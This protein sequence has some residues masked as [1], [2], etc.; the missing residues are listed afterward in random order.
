MLST[1]FT[2]LPDDP[3]Q[4][5]TTHIAAYRP[6]PPPEVADLCGT[7][8]LWTILDGADPLESESW[9]LRRCWLKQN[10]IFGV[11]N[12]S[13]QFR[14][15]AEGILITAS[16]LDNALEV[17]LRQGTKF[18]IL[19]EDMSARPF[20]F[21]IVPSANTSHAKGRAARGIELAAGSEEQRDEWM[22]LLEQFASAVPE[23][24]LPRR[25]PEQVQK[26][27]LQAPV[28]FSNKGLPVAVEAQ[29]TTRPTLPATAE[30]PAARGPSAARKMGF[31]AIP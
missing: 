23:Q 3:F 26:M 19:T 8:A 1:L 10:G 24:T 27:V 4:Y 14:N 21:R 28:K 13:P 7:A 16:E 6:A 22:G 2:E 31:S 11:N 15:T 18:E 25:T 30:E 20:A 29:Q 17:P 9:Q 5:M 12:G